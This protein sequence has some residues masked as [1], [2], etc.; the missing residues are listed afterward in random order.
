MY[1]Y[2]ATCVFM[3]TTVQH[4]THLNKR[5]YIRDLSQVLVALAEQSEHLRPSAEE[6]YNVLVISCLDHGPA[7]GTLQVNYSLTQ[8][9]DLHT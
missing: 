8:V 3:Y 2:S 6:V 4:S 9:N 5:N 1:M 7:V